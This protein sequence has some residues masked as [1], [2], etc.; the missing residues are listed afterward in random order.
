M[1]SKMNSISLNSESEIITLCWN[2]DKIDRYVT[3][4]VIFFDNAVSITE[5]DLSLKSY[6]QKMKNGNVEYNLNKHESNIK[7]MNKLLLH[8]QNKHWFHQYNLS[9]KNKLYS[10]NE[11]ELKLIVSELTIKF[12]ILHKKD[13]NEN[14]IGDLLEFPDWQCVDSLYE[15]I[16]DYLDDNCSIH[17]YFKGHRFDLDRKGFIQI[18]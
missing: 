15:D 12:L 5:F 3:P 14:D 18:V 10:K 6:S 16:G 9:I 4:Y 1:K 11:W 7:K 13:V 2:M 8:L 17:N